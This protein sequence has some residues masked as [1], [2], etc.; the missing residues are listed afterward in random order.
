[1]AQTVVGL[2]QRRPGFAFRLVTWGGG[3]RKA[4]KNRIAGRRRRDL[5]PG[6]PEY[7]AGM[8]TTRPTFGPLA[9]HLCIRG[10][11]LF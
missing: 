7:E 10:T 5:N 2:S 1:M 3:L 8:L 9:G 4:K 11:Y 6:P